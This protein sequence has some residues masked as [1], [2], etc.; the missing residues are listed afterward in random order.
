MYPPGRGRGSNKHFLV[1]LFYRLWYVLDMP[2]LTA[3]LIDGHTYYYARYCQ[4]VDGKP[5]IVR[6]VYLGKIEDLV[7]AEVARQPPQPQETV[8]AAFGDV[9]ALWHVAERLDVLPLL[10]ATLPAKRDQGLSCGQYLLL[11]ALNR[12]VAPTS[13]LQ[14]ADWYRQTALTRLLPA[15]P[16]WLSSQNF[17]NHMDRVTAD[18][19]AAFE[20]QMSRR[21]IE[22]LQ[23]DL[24]ALVYDG[25]NFFTYINT[26]TP[27]ELPQRGHNKQK[28]GDLRQVSL[29][30]LVSTDFHIP[31]LHWVYAGNVADSVE[32]RSVTEE[33]AAHYQELAQTCQHIT[34]VFDKGNNSKEAFDTLAPSPFQ[35]VGSLVPSQHVDLLAVPRR[36]F[37]ALPNPRLEGVEVYRSEKKVF[38]R[39]HT[40]VITFNPNLFDGQLQGLTANLDK[41]RRKLRELQQQLRRWREGKLKGKRPTLAGVQ[42]QVRSICSAQHLKSILKTEVQEVRRGLELTFSTD[43]AALDHL[44]RVQLGKTILF[45]DNADWSDE[46]IVLAYR[47]QYHIEEAFK[48]MK[49]PHFL[50]WSPMFHWTDSKIRVHAFYCVLALTL[51]SV[52]QRELWHKGEQLSIN[53]LLE[54]LGGIRE[55]LVIYPRRQGQRQNRTATCLTRLNPLQQRLFS[56]LDLQ[57]YAPRPR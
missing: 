52:L 17:W 3:K 21:L 53:R 15:D 20:R 46:E 48:Q 8:V 55:T 29:G 32:F 30:L 47:S 43:P 37:R 16:A 45:T 12:A 23:L 2:S 56:L 11:A 5:K 6:T 19:I 57:R 36:H 50:H 51:S 14:F 40:V 35:F 41:A 27:A 7:A 49:N 44:C 33:L 13:K 24:R 25:T 26:R 34:L 10:D 1:D 39:P 28:R 54:E 42:N 38:G 18:H 31:L 22:R 4:R 9:A